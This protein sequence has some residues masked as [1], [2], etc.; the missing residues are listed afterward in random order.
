MFCF[1]WE[2]QLR[3]NGDPWLRFSFKLVLDSREEIT[4][5]RTVRFEMYTCSQPLY[6]MFTMTFTLVLY[7]HLYGGVFAVIHLFLQ[8]ISVI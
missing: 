5:L 6:H 8:E 1:I 3:N 4:L 2:L 7:L